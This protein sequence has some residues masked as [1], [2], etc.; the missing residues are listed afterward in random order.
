[1]QSLAVSLACP[2]S[3]TPPTRLLQ[4]RLVVNLT[5]LRFS[6]RLLLKL[7]NSRCHEQHHFSMMDSTACLDFTVEGACRVPAVSVAGCQFA[8]F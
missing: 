8:T 1:M 3:Q 6:H 5:H 7:A 4:A 2:A